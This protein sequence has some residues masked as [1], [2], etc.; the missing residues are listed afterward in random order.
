[1]YTPL[2]LSLLPADKWYS[3]TLSHTNLQLQGHLP[4]TATT[5][6]TRWRYLVLEL[7]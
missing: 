7:A 6:C 4:G 1:M 3:Y 5:E 2:T